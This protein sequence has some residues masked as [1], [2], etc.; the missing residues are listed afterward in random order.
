MIGALG[1]WLI[2]VPALAQCIPILEAVRGVNC[3]PARTGF[4]AFFLYVGLLYPW[5]VGTAGGV[6]LLWAVIGGLIMMQA[7]G[8]QAKYDDGKKKILYAILGLMIILFS[9]MI[10]NILNPTFYR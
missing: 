6:A 5:L 9:A 1:L 8:D 2:A 3:I 7:G 4:G 10:M